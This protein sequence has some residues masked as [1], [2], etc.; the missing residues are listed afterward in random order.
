MKAHCSALTG[1]LSVQMSAI[2]KRQLVY[3]EHV[4]CATLL[5]ISNALLLYFVSL[6]DYRCQHCKKSLV[7]KDWQNF[8]TSDSKQMHRATKWEQCL[9]AGEKS[10]QFSIS[11]APSSLESYTHEYVLHMSWWEITVNQSAAQI[12]YIFVY[13]RTLHWHLY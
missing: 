1:K 7:P 5:P 2:R 11:W 12:K 9:I 3:F 13:H 8:V 10:K 4:W 6:W